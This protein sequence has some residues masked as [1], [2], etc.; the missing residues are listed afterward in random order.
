MKYH[1]KNTL[2]GICNV[3]IQSGLQNKILDYTSIGLPIIINTDSNN[4]KFLKG[5]NI[6]LY[7][8][9]SEFFSN[10]NKLIKN[11]SL[12][13]K[14]SIINFDKTKKNYIWSKILA[15]YLNIVR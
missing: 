11:K 13:N 14:I 6:L 5:K 2:A 7:K 15:K 12:S 3:K 4:F 10:I 9:K 8:E 1:C